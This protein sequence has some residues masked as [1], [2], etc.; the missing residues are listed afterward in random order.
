M[1]PFHYIKGFNEHHPKPLSTQCSGQALKGRPLGH[2]QV[3]RGHILH[4]PLL[5]TPH[6]TSPQLCHFRKVMRLEDPSW[7]AGGSGLRERPS[8]PQLGL[9]RWTELRPEAP[10]VWPW[11]LAF[12]WS[13]GAWL[14]LTTIQVGA[15]CPVHGFVLGDERQAWP[16]SRS[17]SSQQALKAAC[18][19]T[20]RAVEMLYWN[21]S[22]V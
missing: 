6:P 10:G 22:S 5:D 9:C 20:A 3:T 4:V 1:T 14:S 17:A 19:L 8:H 16:P 21:N 7:G 18:F 12:E 2:T 11:S 15:S 13:G